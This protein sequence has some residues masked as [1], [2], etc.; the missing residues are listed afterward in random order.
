MSETV[1]Y[2]SH[3]NSKL[4]DGNVRT[5]EKEGSITPNG[6]GIECRASG[7]PKIVVNADN[8]FSLVCEKGHGGFYIYCTN[9]DATLEL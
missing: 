8:T 7:N 2:D 9:Y 3:V 5:V 6:L 1:L 4:H